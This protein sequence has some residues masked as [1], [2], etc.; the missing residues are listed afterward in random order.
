MD[1]F[2]D[3]PEKYSNTYHFEYK[4]IE[5]KSLT[6]NLEKLYDIILIEYIDDE[7]LNNFYFELQVFAKSYLTP[8]IYIIDENIIDRFPISFID[9]S[10]DFI[11]KP[12]NKIELYNRFKLVILKNSQLKNNI[13]I[14]RTTK[15]PNFKSFYRKYYEETEKCVRYNRK[16]SVVLIHINNLQVL[17]NEIGWYYCDQI[18]C[19]LSEIITKSFR[20][21]D[22]HS[23]FAFDKF[24]SILPETSDINAKISVE[25]LIEKFKNYYYVSDNPKIVKPIGV[26]VKIVIAEYPTLNQ[27]TIDFIKILNEYITVKEGENDFEIKLLN[28]SKE[29]EKTIL[30]I[31][32]EHEIVNL[33]KELLD[34]YH[35][36]IIWYPRYVSELEQVI[37]NRNVSLL[38]VDI[39]LPNSERNGYEIIEMLRAQ[40]S[41]KN[42]PI[43]VI[44]AKGGPLKIM[45]VGANDYI[46][47]PFK[48]DDL[49]DK[50]NYLLNKNTITPKLINL[51]DRVIDYNKF[52]KI[53]EQNIDE[54]T[55]LPT[56]AGVMDELREMFKNSQNFGVIYINI[57]KYNEIELNYGEKI[58]DNL[59]VKT[60]ALLKKMRG[61]LIRFKDIITIT[62]LWDDDFVIF[63]SPPRRQDKIKLSDLNE[64]KNR[65]E[66]YLRENKST[67]IARGLEFQ[68]DFYFGYSLM[69]IN[70]QIKFERL[71]YNNLKNAMMM[72]FDKESKVSVMLQTEFKALLTDENI[73]ILYQPIVNLED[74]SIIGYE[75]LVRG[76]Q[77]SLLNNPLI[78]FNTAYHSNKIWELERLIRKK[79]IEDYLTFDLKGKYI[80]INVEPHSFADPEFRKFAEMN[81][82]NLNYS[83]FVLE[84]TER[85]HITD[86]TKFNEQ[87]KLFK[88]C[89]FTIA[90][91]DAGSGFASLYYIA[92]I[93]PDIIKL[94]ISLIKN[95]DKNQQ[96]RDIVKALVQFAND[97]H[98][99]VLAEG[100]ERIEELTEIKKIGICYGQ[101]FYFAKP[102][103]DLLT[104]VSL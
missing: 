74:Y 29:Y 30:I 73:N 32:D 12:I 94:D 82:Y 34:K 6:K 81:P 45:E 92:E 11:Y 53:N 22:Y 97:N 44:T 80:S 76:P 95:I 10:S 28:Q 101:G 63:L 49:I 4:L 39:M 89:K 87:L 78:L 88:N 1:D 99:K 96:R 84:I 85:S 86:L 37:V 67:L 91:D 47:K 40:P 23:R 56:I 57:A 3:I 9:E 46:L 65:I 20:N 69:D 13:Q 104:K 21:V 43:L 75:A 90:I 16:M 5:T 26:K 100:I 18:M 36:N 66:K 72:A 98:I 61:T 58:F 31:E 54:L 48:S 7:E 103:R 14:D 17:K 50:V 27:D 59:L 71:V 15:L 24:I 102:S 41:F 52:I 64:V 93:K 2:T 62:R 19:E 60:A 8:I 68:F 25:R 83:N 77:N 33:L 79:I 55:Q 70:Q 35:Y 51:S 38:L 42:L